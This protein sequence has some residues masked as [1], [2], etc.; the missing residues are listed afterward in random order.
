MPNVPVGL[1]YLP[2]TGATP[3]STSLMPVQVVDANGIVGQWQL[4]PVS[5]IAPVSP[6]G[7]F[8]VTDPRWGAK[9]DGIHDDASAINRCAAA[10]AAAGCVVHFPAG[11]YAVGS[12]LTPPTASQWLGDGMGLTILK[13]HASLGANPIIAI[14]GTSG[15]HLSWLWFSDLTIRNGTATTGSYTSGKDGVTAQY[16]DHL[17]FTNVEWTE[18]EGAYGL[19]TKYCTDVLITRS[20][21]YR[22]TYAGFSVQIE[23]DTIRVEDTDFDTVTSTT[24]A[25]TYLFMTGSDTAGVGSYFCKNVWLTRCKFLNNPRWE[26]IDF[27]GGENIWVADCYVENVKTGMLLSATSGFVSSPVMKNVSVTNLI[28]KCGTGNADGAGIVMQG[29]ADRTVLAENITIIGGRLDGFGGTTSNNLGAITVA[30]TRNLKVRGTTIDNYL[31]SGVCLT[32]WVLGVDL[33]EITF[34]D[35]TNPDFNANGAAVALRSVGIYGLRVEACILAPAP[36]KAPN[37]FLGTAQTSV[38][39]QVGTGARANRVLNVKTLRYLNAGNLPVEKS[40]IPTTTLRQ[41]Y[42]DVVL[43]NTG[44]P[45]WYVS[46]PSIGYASLD[47]TTVVVTASITSGSKVAT[48]TASALD[49]RSIPP[50]MNITIVGAGAAGA[51]LNARVLSND[52]TTITLDTAASTTVS[53][54]N[55]KYQALTLVAA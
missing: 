16:V 18:I 35:C 5:A 49:Y 34:R 15:T 29:I 45:G 44:K 33:E 41:Q 38:S 51:D 37:Y 10:A 47:T 12:S 39:V 31:Y 19:M 53:G 3:D 40:V 22:V 14:T 52:V 43:T 17:R 50:G 26:G 25:N 55:V 36:D 42:G 8:T 48:I 30:A 7:V 24:L 54:A 6:N 1:S 28:A 2:Y 20:R 11:T 27:H 21:F 23:C 4:A 9:G 46:A 32:D 13:A